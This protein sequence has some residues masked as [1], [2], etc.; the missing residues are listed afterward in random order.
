MSW[1]LE[2]CLITAVS[3]EVTAPAVSKWADCTQ[4]TGTSG[5]SKFHGTGGRYLVQEHSFQVSNN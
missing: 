5:V 1:V 4:K 2:S 3:V